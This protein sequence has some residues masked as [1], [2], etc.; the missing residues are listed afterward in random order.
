MSTARKN[1]EMS[2]ERIYD[3]LLNARTADKVT[4]HFKD[5]RVIVGALI[6]NPFKGTGRLINVDR[7]QSIDFKVDDIRDLKLQPLSV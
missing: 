1:R 3:A 6:F 4:M 7:E 5:G 2:P